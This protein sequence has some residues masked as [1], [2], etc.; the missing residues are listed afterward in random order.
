M[1]AAGSVKPSPSRTLQPLVIAS[2]H[3]DRQESRRNWHGALGVAIAV[4][5]IQARGARG[6]LPG[7]LGSEKERRRTGWS[8]EEVGCGY[9]A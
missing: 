5:S 9:V 4:Y 7:V 1:F 8:G 6:G 2:P 3:C